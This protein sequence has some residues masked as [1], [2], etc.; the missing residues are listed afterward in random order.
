VSLPLQSS[1]LYDFYEAVENLTS[2]DSS[3]DAGS[4]DNFPIEYHNA[5]ILIGT[6]SIEEHE[7]LNERLSRL[8]TLDDS[9]IPQV[10]ECIHNNTPLPQEF[11]DE[12]LA[13][14]ENSYIDFFKENEG[15]DITN[16]NAI[17]KKLGEYRSLES[18]AIEN[19]TKGTSEFFEDIPEESEAEYDSSLT[20][21]FPDY[22]ETLSNLLDTSRTV[23]FPDYSESFSNL[24]SE[25]STIDFVRDIE[26]TE[27]PNWLD[28]LD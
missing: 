27:M 26:S 25:K 11:I 14:T 9:L 17:I 7:E 20:S 16:P 3:L 18:E 24:F 23:D 8:K 19:I 21:D 10:Q 4:H 22:S 12:F 6:S 28:E 2:P 13:Y 15:I 5:R 1:S